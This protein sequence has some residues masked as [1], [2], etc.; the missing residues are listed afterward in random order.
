[1]GVAA[2]G[3]VLSGYLWWKHIQAAAGY[4]VGCGEAGGCGDLWIGR[5]STVLSVVPVAALATGFYVAVLA[6]L[7]KVRPG[8]PSGG[9]SGG[10]AVAA[11]IPLGAATW[12]VFLQAQVLEQ[13]CVLCLTDHAVGVGL[14]AL[15]LARVKP[16]VWPA[17]GAGL[18]MVGVMAAMQ[19][20]IPSEPTMSPEDCVS[21]AGVATSGSAVEGQTLQLLDGAFTLD[22]AEEIVDG[23]PASGRHLV[24]LFDYQ[25]PHCRHAWEVLQPL[26]GVA[27][28]SL[29]VPLNPDC[30][31]HV[32]ALPKDFFAAS[33]EMAR[34]AV[35]LNRVDPSAPAAFEAWAF[36]DGWPHTAEQTRAF[37]QTLVDPRRP[38]RGSG[39]PGRRRGGAA[40]RRALGRPQSA[41]PRRPARPPDPRRRDLHRPR[42][43]RQYDPRSA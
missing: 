32:E 36:G 14:A 10:L 13:W 8:G 23:D 29:P 40:Q 4:C 39:R 28:V 42:R 12:F 38:G 41:G 17:A 18:A 21:R 26:D 43:R 19:W 30:N 3:L 33:C 5:W 31:P 1:M 25:C 24:K 37:A 22:L 6:Y 27:V 11:G 15:L 9:T 35:A 16:R 34:L 7:W 20:S 2:L